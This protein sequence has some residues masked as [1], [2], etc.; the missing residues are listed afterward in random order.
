MISIPAILPKQRT[1]SIFRL[2]VN[3]GLLLG[4]VGLHPDTPRTSQTCDVAV[5]GHQARSVSNRLWANEVFIGGTLSPQR[6][7]KQTLTLNDQQ[8]FVPGSQAAPMLQLGQ[9]KLG[10]HLCFEVRFASLLMEQALQHVDAFIALA[11]MAGPDDQQ[12]AKQRLIPAMY[13]TRAAEFVTPLVLCNTLGP[14]PWLTSGA[15]D[16]AGSPIP[17]S[18]SGALTTQA[19]CSFYDIRPRDRTDPW[20]NDLFKQSREHLV[21]HPQPEQVQTQ[22]ATQAS[23][24]VAAL[25]Q[26]EQHSSMDHQT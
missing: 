25:P 1:S 15:W 26:S 16:A 12:G 14:Q 7:R 2:S 20:L 10:L 6:Y 9:W 3:I 4:T 17:A 21:S 11:H 13:A 23:T 24:Q 18:T 19:L 8:Y 5:G 22:V